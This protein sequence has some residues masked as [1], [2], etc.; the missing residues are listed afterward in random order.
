MKYT[1]I[2]KNY[3]MNNNMNTL[4]PPSSWRN[5]TLPGSSNPHVAFLTASLPSPPP[6]VTGTLNLGLFFPAILKIEYYLC[7]HPQRICCWWMDKQYVEYPYNEISISLKSNEILTHATLWMN[8]ED[9]TLSE[10][11]RHKRTYI[12]WFHLYEE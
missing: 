6:Q 5:R 10:T 8:L 1:Y 12:A 3:L 4:Y 9:I 7:M 2:Y 11:N